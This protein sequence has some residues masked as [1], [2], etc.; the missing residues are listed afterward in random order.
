MI[1]FTEFRPFDQPKKKLEK[2]DFGEAG[3]GRVEC[4]V[5]LRWWYIPL[6]K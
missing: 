4:K 1:I 2:N 3:N 6:N 5:G